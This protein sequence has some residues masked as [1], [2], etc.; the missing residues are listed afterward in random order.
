MDFLHSLL[1][2][3]A[4]YSLAMKA[5]GGHNSR[6]THITRYVRPKAGDRIL[7]VG[8][9]PADILN[10]LP[11]VSYIGVDID[12]NYI[13]CAKA[14]FADRGE[15]I[16]KDV[17]LLAEECFEPVD[18]ILATGL[19]HHLTDS[20][21]INLLKSC[22]KLLKPSG[23]MVTFDGCRIPNQHPFDTWMLNNDRGQY[24]RTEEAYRKLAGSV[25][26]GVSMNIHSNLLRIPYTLAIMELSHTGKPKAVSQELLASRGKRN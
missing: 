25:F 17:A 23:R 8:C 19:L 15:F 1:G 20:E 9:G 22:K 12:A 16:C 14:H 24:V 10:Y 11:A 3:P 26:P 13:A 4:L 5:L 2:F 6:T 7:D 21:C 18:I